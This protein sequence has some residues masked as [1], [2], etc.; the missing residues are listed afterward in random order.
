LGGGGDGGDG[1]QPAQHH[2]LLEGVE[3]VALES[4]DVMRLWE[5]QPG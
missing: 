4:H 1:V 2:P 5:V 3:F